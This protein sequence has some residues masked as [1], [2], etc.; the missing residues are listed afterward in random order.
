MYA[1]AAARDASHV[2]L[3]GAGSRGRV[4]HAR[5]ILD[6]VIH[7]LRIHL[8]EL[9]RIEGGDA[10]GHILQAFGALLRSDH[11]LLERSGG[12]LLGA[13]GTETSQYRGGQR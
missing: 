3:R 7:R 1:I 9:R 6:V 10:E 11:D 4:G 12:R 5:E 2:D 8:F 13:R